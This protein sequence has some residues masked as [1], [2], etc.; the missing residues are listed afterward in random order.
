VR[1][2]ADPA[3]RTMVPNVRQLP[4]NRHATP[5]LSLNISIA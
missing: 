4:N 3:P 2:I 5:H 1:P